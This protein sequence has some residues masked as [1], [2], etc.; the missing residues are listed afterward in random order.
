MKNKSS[1]CLLD[2]DSIQSKGN[3]K[4]DTCFNIL[5]ASCGTKHYK[6]T[7]VW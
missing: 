5:V 4:Y 7:I 1:L 3:S 2:V 6:L